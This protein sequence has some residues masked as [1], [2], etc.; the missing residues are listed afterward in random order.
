M[1]VCD[2]VAP[3]PRLEPRQPPLS[4]GIYALPG[5]T[6]GGVLERDCAYLRLERYVSGAI[7]VGVGAVAVVTGHRRAA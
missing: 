3:D 6:L 4:D 2:S 7:L 5:G 1:S